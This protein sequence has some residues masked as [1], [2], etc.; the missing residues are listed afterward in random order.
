MYP[1]FIST[2]FKIVLNLSKLSSILTLL[3]YTCYTQHLN[4][5]PEKITPK[6]DKI[7]MFFKLQNR[8]WKVKKMSFYDEDEDMWARWVLIGQSCLVDHVGR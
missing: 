3:T 7:Y 2:I 1:K 8:Q 6:T 5:I 4:D